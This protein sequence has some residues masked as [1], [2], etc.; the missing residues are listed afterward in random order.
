MGNITSFSSQI[1]DKLR[2]R[3]QDVA[4]LSS[5]HSTLKVRNPQDLKGHTR[6]IPA[7]LEAD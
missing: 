1:S 5:T 7:E 4:R 3:R 2:S 6:E